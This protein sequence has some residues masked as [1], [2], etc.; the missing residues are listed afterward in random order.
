MCGLVIATDGGL[1]VHPSL[2]ALRLVP[3]PA[4]GLFHSVSQLVDSFAIADDECQQ[5]LLTDLEQDTFGGLK[6]LNAY[7]LRVS[8]K[9][10]TAPHSWGSQ[11]YSCPCGCRPAFSEALLSK[12]ISG[13][14]VPCLV[15]ASD[16]PAWRHLHPKELAVLNGCDPGWDFGPSLRLSLALLGQVASPLQAAWVLFQLRAQVSGVASGVRCA[17]LGLCA[18]RARLV[19]QAAI[20]GLLSEEGAVKA[21]KLLFCPC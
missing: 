13:V 17:L 19:R 1:L 12:G 21:L 16:Q 4:E 8:G 11:I 15:P 18:L 7:C 3:W 14:L 10:P 6:P 9:L 2:Q 20:A 5:L